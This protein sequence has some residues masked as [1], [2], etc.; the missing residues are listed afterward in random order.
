M[1]MTG[2][3]AAAGKQVVAGARLYIAEHGDFVA[4]K[5][6]ELIVRDDMSSF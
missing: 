3:L 1:P 5:H 2:T 6:V 4:G